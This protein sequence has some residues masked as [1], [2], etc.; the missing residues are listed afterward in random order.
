MLFLASYFHSFF[1]NFAFLLE[2]LLDE[3]FWQIILG[4]R[5]FGLVKRYIGNDAVMFGIF[6]SLGPTILSL[7]N[8]F[9]YWIKSFFDDLFHV[10][11]EITSKQAIYGPVQEYIKQNYKQLPDFKHVSG[12]TMY[13]T[14]KR[15]NHEYE[16]ERVKLGLM[17][18][19]GTMRHVYYKGNK[20]WVNRFTRSALDRGNGNNAAAAGGGDILEM[21]SG[22]TEGI[23]ISINSM[24]SRNLGLLQ[25]IIQEWIDEYY[26]MRDN[27][28]IVYK[29]NTAS[30]SQE[31]EELCTKEARGF[32]SVILKK[33]QKEELY[34]DVMAFRSQKAWY[35]RKGI[36]YRRGYLLYGPPGTGKTSFIQSLA[37]KVDM[38][39]ALISITAS[40]DD[41]TFTN[42]LVHVPKNTIV[43]ME[44]VDHCTINDGDEDDSGSSSR[45]R[46]SASGL[47]NAMDGVY[48]P[49]GCLIFLTCNDMTKIVP[50]LLRPGR[51]DVK[52]EFGYA[53]RY[54][55]EAMFWRFFDEESQNG[56]DPE[57]IDIMHKL[58]DVL[59]ENELTPA[60]LQNF[61]MAHALLLQSPHKTQAIDI[62]R[63]TDNEDTKN[64]DMDANEKRALFFKDLLASVDPFMEKVK[65]DREQARKHAERKLKQRDEDDD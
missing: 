25:T 37:A 43:V 26:R 60:E 5:W 10:S 38:N 8:S 18:H 29:A 19:M 61:F 56:Q 58:L 23:T 35:Q 36:P 50:A 65:I 44:D 3:S 40:M 46:L 22:S 47:L 59:P 21:L 42:L 33:N 16:Q 62:T 64:E 24:R 4:Q 34:N 7:F 39:V 28:L 49:E 1:N 30:W 2:T 52:M 17:P 57:W 14:I 6:L 63:I 20:L 55:T 11:I 12:V 9:F 15:H 41:E 48:S 31:W 51:V 45:K 53:D 54:Q 27:Q 32:E 13:S